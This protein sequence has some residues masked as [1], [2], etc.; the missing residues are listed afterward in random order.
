M[1]G[2]QPTGSQKQGWGRTGTRGGRGLELRPHARALRPVRPSSSVHPLRSSV[3]SLPSPPTCA[4]P[5]PI[6]TLPPPGTP[7]GSRA[8]TPRGARWESTEEGGGEPRKTCR[9]WRA[10]CAGA[11][12][13]PAPRQAVRP[14]LKG[15][16]RGEPMEGERAGAGRSGARP[17]MWLLR[18][19]L[20]RASLRD[21]GRAPPLACWS[22]RGPLGRR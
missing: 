22:P 8:P 18:P 1:W 3:P 6:P 4:P 13:R 12:C 7:S 16:Q 17:R 15:G 9:G 11:E 21:P 5:R 2:K 20:P 14:Y 10:R 19:L